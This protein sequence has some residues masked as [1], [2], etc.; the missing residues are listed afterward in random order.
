MIEKMGFNS[1]I[2]EGE[3]KR[4]TSIAGIVRAAWNVYGKSLLEDYTTEPE[5]LIKKIPKP[6][7]EKAVDILRRKLTKINYIKEEQ[8]IPDKKLKKL[9]KIL[10]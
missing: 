1:N 3:I 8:N 5:N 9:Q 7:T 4:I 10:Y 2:K 6:K